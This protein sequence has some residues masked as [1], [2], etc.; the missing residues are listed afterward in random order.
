MFCILGWRGADATSIVGISGSWYFL[1][2]IAMNI[3]G[4]GE[5]ILGNTLPFAVFVIYGC[6]WVNIAYTGD[7]WHPL[8]AAYGAGGAAG[9]PWNS[10]QA[11]YNVTMTLV[12]FVF[13]LGALRTNVPFVLAFFCLIFLFSF[14]AAADW[15]IGYATGPAD[16]EYAT[17]LLKIAG[18]FGFV[19]A[20]CGW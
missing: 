16:L 11:F 5:F 18:G 7:P 9:K 14:F 15:Q 17:Y 19:T 10:G 2:G 6:H 1:G 4:I 12:S 8:V 13:M 3:A 20:L